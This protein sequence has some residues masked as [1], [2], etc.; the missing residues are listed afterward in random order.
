MTPS[1]LI[2]TPLLIGFLLDTVIGDPRWLPHPIRLFGNCISFLTKKLNKG[3]YRQAKGASMATGLIASTYGILWL[4]LHLAETTEF[5]YLAL[6]SLGVFYGLANRSLISEAHR[7][8]SALEKYGLEAGRKQLSQIVGRETH[9][10]NEHQIHTAVLETLAEN[11]S[12]GVIAPL[13]FYAV[14]GV[15]AMLAYKMANTLDSMIGYK[16]EQFLH[17]G[18]V[19]ARLDD[20]LN[21]VPA[22]ITALM[23]VVLCFSGRGLV[24]IFRYGHQHCSPNAGYPEAALAG[25]LNSRLGGPAFYHGTLVEKPY[26]GHNNRFFSRKDFNQ[27]YL[28]NLCTCLLMIG[29]ICWGQLFQ[30]YLL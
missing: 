14:G 17:F 26:I 15:P 28:I 9:N 20:I 5:L 19:A 2:I 3:N 6:A 23:M 8:I 24:F 7:V 25:I 11:L 30:A 18:R 13:F 1:L 27:S 22:R 29:L 12:D 10:L 16:S 21:F 4:I